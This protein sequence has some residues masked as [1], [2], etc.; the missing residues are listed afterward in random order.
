MFLL[1]NKKTEKNVFTTMRTASLHRYHV[2]QH[3]AFDLAK[4]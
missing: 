4:L 1:K 2:K 3:S